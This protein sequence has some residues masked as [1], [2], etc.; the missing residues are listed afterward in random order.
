MIFLNV[1]CRTSPLFLP[2]L[3]T[4]QIAYTLLAYRNDF[5]VG[6]WSMLAHVFGRLRAPF[7]AGT[8]ALLTDVLLLDEAV[9][10][11]RHYARAASFRTLFYMKSPHQ[12][13][14]YGMIC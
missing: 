7:L 13:A 4:M 12:S 9:S 8:P 3:L 2:C 1:E 5:Q 10:V 14:V 11:I 6:A